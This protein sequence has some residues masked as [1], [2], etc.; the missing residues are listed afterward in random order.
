MTLA[1]G[2]QLGRY[3]IERTLG[4]GGM[5]EVYQARD[6]RLHRQVAVKVLPAASTDSRGRFRRFE[7]E[8]RSAAALSHANIVAVYDVG[9]ADGLAY[10]VT[11]L[12]EGGTLADLVSR[13]PLSPSTLFA[14]TVPIADALAAAH[15]RGIVHRDLK[16]ANILL[17]AEGVPKIA[18][19]G[20]AKLL[21]EAQPAGSRNPTATEDA[22]QEG[23]V[24]GTVAY[25]S[26][27]QARGD[28]L[29]FR[30]DQFS[31]GVILYELVTGSNPF[32]HGNVADTFAAI[33]REDPAFSEKEWSQFSDTLREF[34]RRCISK[35]LRDRYGSTEDLVR[36]F[37]QVAAGAPVLGAAPQAT[38][39][40]R[41][42]RAVWAPLALALFALG[43][44][45][46]LLPRLRPVAPSTERTLAVLP[47]RSFTAGA[48]DT[49]LRLGLADALISK[50][51]AFRGLVVRPTTAVRRFES[52]DA[53]AAKVGKELGVESVLQG[54]VQSAGDRLRISAQLVRARDQ[55]TLWGKTFDDERRNIF[56]MQ[57][58]IAEE[59]IRALGV[60]ASADEKRRLSLDYTANL[61]AYELYQQARAAYL[62][63]TKAENARAIE[64]FAKAL[65]IDPD[66]APAHAFLAIACARYSFQYF[67][68]N[69]AWAARAEEE[70]SLSIQKGPFLAEAHQARAQ[71]L[72]SLHQNFDFE[73]ALSEVRRALELSPN[74][75]LAHYWLGVGYCGHL[76]LF[77]EGIAELKRATDINPAWSAPV[78]SRCWLTYMQG[79]YEEAAGFCRQGISM[80]PKYTVA[81]WELSEILMRQGK[82]RE[83]AAECAQALQFEPKNTW[84]ISFQ[85]VIAAAAGHAEEASRLLEQAIQTYDDHHVQ[86]NAACVWSLL[87]ENDRAL[88]SLRRVLAGNF[89]PYPWLRI[90]PLLDN[91]RKN[92]GFAKLL[93][94]SRGRYEAD[95]RA[96]A[97]ASKDARGG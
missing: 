26:P 44:A 45:V 30:S 49:A 75:D 68:A 43:G 76:G 42:G 63:N 77:E 7:R 33:L 1:S 22:T 15:R 8:A 62:A 31:F 93:E 92:P 20:L 23:S 86:Y 88:V 17:T 58:R 24:L 32:R 61:S 16:P 51:S 9:E 14:I 11:E 39:R 94:D 27:E 67:D 79:R 12:L 34:V 74:L 28:A 38:P 64:L 72:S 4:I 91:L 36:D 5:G 54:S 78:V 89:N 35:N 87:N 96:Y 10:I 3:Q 13:G 60:T 21:P 71:V 29:D 41:R 47:F 6:T 2:T 95:Q 69:P 85:A 82:A 90:D 18:D 56:S 83:A 66:Y 46:W 19:F 59:V 50:L 52:T 65:E 84:A 48:E 53:D 70:A 97:T 37:R 55:R 57:D 40:S 81:H 73:R 80:T 25:M